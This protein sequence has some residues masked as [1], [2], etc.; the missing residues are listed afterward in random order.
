VIDLALADPDDASL[1]PAL[2]AAELVKQEHRPR[3]RRRKT[4]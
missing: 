2:V 4:R 3:R 1:W